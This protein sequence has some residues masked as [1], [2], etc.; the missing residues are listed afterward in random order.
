LG[1]LGEACDFL[2]FLEVPWGGLGSH[3]EAWGT[4]GFLGF[5]G[6]LWKAWGSMGRLGVSWGRIEVPL[7]SLGFLG[8]AW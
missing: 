4:R 7:S 2:G 1:F 8:E 6:F 3:G 5:L